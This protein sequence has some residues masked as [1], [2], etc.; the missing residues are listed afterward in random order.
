MLSGSE[1]GRG[2]LHVRDIVHYSVLPQHRRVKQLAV[3]A[4]LY[5]NLGRLLRLG[6][7]S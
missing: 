6:A 4:H 1:R 2:R 7:A 3:S 5:E